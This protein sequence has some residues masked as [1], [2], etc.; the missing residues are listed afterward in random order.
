MVDGEPVPVG[1]YSKKL[2]DSEKK[3][4]TFD[5]ELLAAYKAVL[6]FKPQIEGRITTLLTDHKPLACA[7][8]KPGLMKSDKQQRHLSLITEYISDISHI[9]GHQNIV[10]DCLSRP[11]NAVSVDLFDLP[12]LAENQK[13]D[14][15]INGYRDKLIPFKISPENSVLCDT[16]TPYP[17]PYVP[18]KCR[19]DVFNSLHSLS[20]PGVRATSKLVKARYYWPHMDK[21]IKTWTRE[22]ASC[23]QSKTIKHTKSEII[24]F[25]L[26]SQRFE[27]VHIDIVGPLPVAKNPTDS[28]IS[29]YRY[30]L[31]C[32]DRATR[33]LEAAPLEDITAASVAVAFV[34]TW[35]SRFGVPLYVITDRG[36]QFESELF[37]E[38]SALV[39]FH[40]LRTT[41][42][43]AQC[44]GMIERQH[45]TLKTAITARKE[46]WLQALPV[47]LLSIRNIPN[48]SGFSPF[49]AV[50]GTSLLFP[51]P[52]ISQDNL[53]EETSN[54]SSKVV[55]ELSQQMSKI[56]FDELSTGRL[57]SR[58]K[59]FI[60]E[61]LKVCSHVWIRVDRIR[62]PLEAPYM[63]PFKVIKR[64]DKFF[65]IET[66]KGNQQSISID[67]LK[68][69]LFP[70]N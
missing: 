28:F 6:H 44:N 19:K 56:N 52:L 63:G 65:V 1:F 22:C 10:A 25:N 31:T 12:A 17:R 53:C 30:L 37:K 61:D 55:K 33:W 47:V 20:H 16:S 46:D 34:N 23:Q 57:H 14:P 48:E 18:I 59:S 29:P 67:R 62:K 60:P 36:M 45:R 41:P 32:V 8:K 66:V 49:T 13:T 26:P 58:P 35:V 68:P 70:C 2:S 27:T 11:V 24:N 50:T 15:E 21:N 9:K 54:L 39:G 42:Y 64:S 3:T 4:S 69:V 5:R 7:Y 51:R 43:H 38:L 40:R